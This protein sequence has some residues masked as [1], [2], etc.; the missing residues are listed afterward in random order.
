VR[1]LSQLRGGWSAPTALY[2]NDIPVGRG[3]V[4]GYDVLQFRVSVN[5]IVNFI[6]GRNPGGQPRDLSVL[7]TDGLGNRAS[8]LVS[9]S[10][11]ALFFPPGSDGPDPRK[12]GVP[13]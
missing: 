8:A 12:T 1:G 6:D 4:L 10:S 2:Q 3:N 11:Q 9:D 13:D 7:L 5:F